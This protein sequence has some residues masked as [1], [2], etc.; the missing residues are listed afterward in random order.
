MATNPPPRQVVQAAWLLWASLAV[1]L[2]ELAVS[3]NPIRE[4]AEVLPETHM[5]AL[6]VFASIALIGTAYLWLVHHVRKGHN[7][8]RITILVLVTLGVVESLISRRTHLATFLLNLIEI[9]LD[10]A[11]LA[12]LFSGPASHWF[13]RPRS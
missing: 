5:T 12:L 1:G 6:G 4:P 11:A 7:W 10:V 13:N 8:A 2:V 9:L 3:M